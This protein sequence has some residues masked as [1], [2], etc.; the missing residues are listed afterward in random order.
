MCV[1]VSVCVNDQIIKIIRMY[2]KMKKSKQETGYFI[3]R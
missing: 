1:C 3:F 2:E